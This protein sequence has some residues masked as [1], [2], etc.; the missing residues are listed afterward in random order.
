MK[1]EEKM[2][3]IYSF[4]F[5]NVTKKEWVYLSRKKVSATNKQILAPTKK[6]FRH[7]ELERV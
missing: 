3:K 6:V 1:N 7:F 4:Q 2:K 5:N